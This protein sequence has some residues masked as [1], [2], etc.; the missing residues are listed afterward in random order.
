MFTGFIVVHHYFAFRLG[1][2]LLFF[3]QEKTHAS[4]GDKFDWIKFEHAEHGP[5][6][7]AHGCAE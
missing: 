2:E 5:K 7:G 6:G 3:G 1:G 4:R